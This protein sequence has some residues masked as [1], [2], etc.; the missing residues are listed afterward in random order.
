MDN[1]KEEII[2]AG[3]LIEQNGKFILVQE[4]RADSRGM[5]NFPMG[6]KEVNEDII[7]CAKREGK[8]E[9]GLDLRPI[10]LIGKYTFCLPSGNKV[11]AYIFKSE[12]VGGKLSTPEDMMDVRQFSLEEIK[13]LDEKSIAPFINNVIQDYKSGERIPLD[14]VDL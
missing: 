9:T 11:I 10:Y 7:S 13:E 8:E 3:N 5:W 2:A 14:E 1:L 4:K 12:I 6:R